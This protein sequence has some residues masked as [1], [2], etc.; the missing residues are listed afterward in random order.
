MSYYQGLGSEVRIGSDLC[1]S[2]SSR[3]HVVLTVGN[4]EHSLIDIAEKTKLLSTFGQLQIPERA[5][6]PQTV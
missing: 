1:Q 6:E 3:K 5:K 4:N 2:A